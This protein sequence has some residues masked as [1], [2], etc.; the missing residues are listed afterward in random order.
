MTHSPLAA[1]RR[2]A[3]VGLLL[4]LAA[5]GKAPQEPR[6]DLEK[7]SFGDLEGWRDDN[8]G[9]AL[10]A[11]RRSCAKMS[12]EWRDVCDAAGVL[13]DDDDGAARDFLEPRFTPLR[14][15]DRGETEGLFTGYYEPLLNGAGQPGGRFTVPIHGLP[16]TM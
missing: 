11:F 2:I 5:C 16:S 12:A 7:I 15:S 6:L 10:A 13:A 4:A 8:Q 3:I 14:M 1:F 9:L